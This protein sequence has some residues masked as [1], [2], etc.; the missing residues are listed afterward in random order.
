[1]AYSLYTAGVRD[2]V[3]SV[4][5]NGTAGA[6]VDQVRHETGGDGRHES[7]PLV[8]WEAYSACLLV[9]TP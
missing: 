1:M 2:F 6:R 4:A 5:V 3:C 7:C 8:Q 9:R